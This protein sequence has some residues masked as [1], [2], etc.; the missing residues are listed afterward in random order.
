MASLVDFDLH[1]LAAELA[2]HDVRPAHARTILRTFYS[3]D[4]SA[5]WVER[6]IGRV[7]VR[8]LSERFA[9]S[10]AEI[11]RRHESADGTVKLLLEL[12]AGGAVEAVLMPTF[13]DEVAAG[14]VSSQVG[15]A[16]G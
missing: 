10:P 11:L 13:R 16:M 6:E 2:A 12:K 5:K 8:L 9:K 14:C 3:S 7:A 4:G 1:S 15:C